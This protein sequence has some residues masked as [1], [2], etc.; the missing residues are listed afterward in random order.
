MRAQTSSPTQLRLPF[1]S[2]KFARFH[3][4][5]SFSEKN[6][7]FKYCRKAGIPFVF[8]E[9][10]GSRATVEFDYMAFPDPKFDLVLRENSEVLEAGMAKLRHRYKSRGTES[11]TSAVF[12]SY[13]NIRLDKA[14]ALAE[15]LYD[16]ISRVL[17]RGPG[18]SSFVQ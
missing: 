13:S 7:W 6:R 14:D 15:E 4:D 12:A 17:D 11:W 9:I 18:W 8:V 10:Q 16:L 3:F 5:P 1:L 2:E